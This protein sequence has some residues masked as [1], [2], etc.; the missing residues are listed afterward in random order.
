M[1]DLVSTI[2]SGNALL[3]ITIAVLIVLPAI[4][5]VISL[6]IKKPYSR[7]AAV[8][9]GA[10]IM[11]IS[12]LFL[13]QYMLKNGGVIVIQS[14][15]FVEYLKYFFLLVD[16][17]VLAYVIVRG[18]KDRKYFSPILAL[19]QFF[20][21]FYV[22]FIGKFHEPSTII[23]IDNLSL[24]MVLLISIVGSLILYFGIGYM[25]NHEAHLHLKKTRQPR[26]YA[27]M[28]LFLSAMNMLV[29][30][31]NL[32]FIYTVWEITTL[33]SFLLI[34]HDMTE[35]SINNAYR[36][37][38]LN[39]IGGLAFIIGIVC[40]YTNN[41][42]ISLNDW[43]NMADYS[44]A[45]IAAAFLILAGMIKSAQ[46]PFQSWLLGAMVAPSP[47]SALL[48][49]STMVKA[50][51]YLVLRMS[52]IMHDQSLAVAVAVAG[53]FTFMAA[54]AIAINQR[55]A[56]KLLAYSTIAN[57]GLII[58]MTGVGT[59][60]ALAAGIL[61]IIFHGVSKSLLFLCVG[62]IEQEIG[63]RDIEDMQGLLKIM[64]FTTYVTV[65]GMVSMLLPPFGVL[66]TKLLAIE[67]SVGLPLV[68]F[69]IIMGSAFTVVFWAKWIG[70]IL[71]MSYKEKHVREK[72][73]T[74]MRVTLGIILALVVLSSVFVARVYDSLIAPYVLTGVSAA[75]GGV[76]LVANGNWLTVEGS[77]MLIGSYNAVP[78]FAIIFLLAVLFPILYRG[79]RK[80]KIKPPYAGGELANDDIRG[81]DYVGPMD[82]VYKIEVHNYYFSNIFRTVDTLIM[83]VS[84]SIILV[85]F[86]VTV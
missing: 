70:I 18:A 33:C 49:S 8:L 57:L 13:L 78:F 81:I 40:L 75:L 51:V 38:N 2:S 69:L 77:Q 64:P 79:S 12:A 55:N 52:P 32:L 74:T 61:L 53:G 3:D 22:L 11:I 46:F 58:C 27:I 73:R 47:V 68:L 82:K 37:L 60:V 71:T 10:V 39:M 50:G 76:K 34:S 63:S 14:E 54:S 25:D 30:F 72:M 66:F 41:N 17:V 9:F 20:V 19:L 16:I 44:P 56:K 4:L 6:L 84:I 65:I 1:L 59:P 15:H 86:G 29:M 62:S 35:E 26:F 43:T 80:E 23:M 42:T 5:A 31:D 83:V 28:Y 85:M 7:G 45:L 21:L 67:A 24:V 48:H 36:T